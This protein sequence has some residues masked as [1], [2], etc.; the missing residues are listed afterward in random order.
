MKNISY[1]LQSITDEMKKGLKQ[2]V[3]DALN[4]KR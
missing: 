2:S 1:T 4:E 3:E